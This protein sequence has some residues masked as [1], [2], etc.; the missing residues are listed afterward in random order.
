M[1]RW[2]QLH[3]A[4][5]RCAKLE[6]RLAVLVGNEE[7]AENNDIHT[8]KNIN[9]LEIALHHLHGGH[10]IACRNKHVNEIDIRACGTTDATDT[11]LPIGL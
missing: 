8:N 4:L 5:R 3:A 2:L 6:R 7:V 9:I 1:L 11:T 10:G